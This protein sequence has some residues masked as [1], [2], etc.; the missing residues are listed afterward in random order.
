MPRG[1]K[2]ASI[3]GYFRNILEERPD[4]LDS[5]GS[6]SILMEMWGRD[7][8]SQSK[9]KRQ[10]VVQNLAN[11]KSLL[12]RQRDEGKGA[13]RGARAAVN[14]V[15]KSQGSS[16]LAVL[17]AQIDDCLVLARRLDPDGLQSVIQK[18]RSAR[19]EVAW[20]IGE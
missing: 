4:L 11:L 8:P 12:R 5:P 9:A 20:K 18:L 10:K 7:H 17:E 14:S 15:A 16:E 1:R 3:S 6:N 13:R 2:K 19:N